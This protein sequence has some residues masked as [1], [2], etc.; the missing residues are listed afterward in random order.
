[1][2]KQFSDDDIEAIIADAAALG[3]KVSHSDSALRLAWTIMNRPMCHT[4]FDLDT[5][6]R[7]QLDG[8]TCDTEMDEFEAQMC[9]NGCCLNICAVPDH[10]SLMAALMT[11]FGQEQAAARILRQHSYVMILTGMD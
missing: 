4:R 8:T 3:I 10:I 7:D 11:S 1:M 9:A 2:D 5:L 6:E